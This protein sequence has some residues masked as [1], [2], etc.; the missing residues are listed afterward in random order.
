[1]GRL[2]L[3]FAIIMAIAPGFWLRTMYGPG[4]AEYGYVLRL[5]ALLYVIIFV[6]GPIRAGLQAMEYHST[7]FLVLSGDDYIYGSFRISI[8]QTV[9]IKWRNARRPW[10]STRVSRLRRRFIDSEIESLEQATGI[11]A[12]FTGTIGQ[13]FC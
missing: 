8:D 11:S 1:M 6:G 3:L 12:R 10:Y 2:T 13:R 5:Y 4:I 7:D 9:W